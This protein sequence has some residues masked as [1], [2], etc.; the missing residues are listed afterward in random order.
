M[1]AGDALGDLDAAEKNGVF[2]YP[3]LVSR[4]AESWEQMESAVEKMK[5]G[6]FAGAQSL[7]CCC[8]LPHY[9]PTAKYA[10]LHSPAE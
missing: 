7:W 9:Y 6:A 1:M 8:S 2:Y 10:P 4:E 3:I 5:N